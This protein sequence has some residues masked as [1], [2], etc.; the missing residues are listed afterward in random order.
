V[1][2]PSVTQPG[3]AKAGNVGQEAETRPKTLLATDPSHPV[4]S[5][6]KIWVNSCVM[7]ISIQSSK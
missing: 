2:I 3:A 6:A 7:T 1:A 5:N 4:W